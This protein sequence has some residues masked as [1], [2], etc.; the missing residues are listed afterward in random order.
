MGIAIPPINLNE[1]KRTIAQQA[2][3]CKFCQ[4][5]N[6]SVI[7]Q[8]ERHGIYPAQACMWASLL[9]E[10]N[11]PAKLTTW[12]F[13]GRLNEFSSVRLTSI[14]RTCLKGLY[15][16]PTG[17]CCEYPSKTARQI[18]ILTIL[19]VF[20]TIFAC[21]GIMPTERTQHENAVINDTNDGRPANE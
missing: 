21:R 1:S 3:V 11:R 4:G 6:F 20:D 19:N 15:A 7:A 17:K 8:T 5:E 14:V 2:I 9:N 12:Q 10:W 18:R 16:M 13:V